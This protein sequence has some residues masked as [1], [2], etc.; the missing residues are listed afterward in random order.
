MVE[1]IY[2]VDGFFCGPPGE[3]SRDGMVC[4]V[5]PEF[6]SVQNCQSGLGHWETF[7]KHSEKAVHA[8]PVPF[9]LLFLKYI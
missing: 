8:I 2:G 1:Q 9:L 6:N 7:W 5:H 3:W 4:I